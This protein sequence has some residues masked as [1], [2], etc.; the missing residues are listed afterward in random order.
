MVQL[1]RS[2]RTT[3][4]GNSANTNPSSVFET[5]TLPLLVVHLSVRGRPKHDV[6]FISQPGASVSG[7]N[8]APALIWSSIFPPGPSTSNVN[9]GRLRATTVTPVQMPFIS[10][11]PVHVPV[12]SSS[13][14]FGNSQPNPAGRH[15]MSGSPTAFISSNNRVLPSGNSSTW[16]VAPNG[17]TSP[18]SNHCQI[19]AAEADATVTALTAQTAI[20]TSPAIRRFFTLT[21]LSLTRPSRPSLA[22]ACSSRPQLAFIQVRVRKTRLE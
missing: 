17:I 16:S 11:A 2:T 20:A 1:A 9:H 22:E 13:S 14:P 8:P 21:Y 15:K 19:S 6:A 7:F 3:S 5:F 10:T 18:S 4:S 12:S